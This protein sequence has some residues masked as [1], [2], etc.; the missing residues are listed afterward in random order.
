MDNFSVVICLIPA[1]LLLVIAGFYF[2]A[3][4]YQKET[5]SQLEQL[6]GDWRSY[7]TASQQIAQSMAE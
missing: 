4:Y 6:R 5:E 2:L 3:R 7:D 1:A